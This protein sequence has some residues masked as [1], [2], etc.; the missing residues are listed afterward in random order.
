MMVTAVRAIFGRSI[1][2]K[3]ARYL[4]PQRRFVDYYTIESVVA[5]HCGCR[6]QNTSEHINRNFLPLM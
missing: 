3:I 2:L 6:T 4:N 1:Q 5:L